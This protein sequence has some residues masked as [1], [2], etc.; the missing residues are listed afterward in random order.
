MIT[1]A[2]PRMGIQ[3]VVIWPLF[4]VAASLFV[5]M[6]FSP[7]KG[8]ATFSY[9]CLLVG[10]LHR[11]NRNV[12]AGLMSTGMSLDLLL[13]LVLEFQRSAIAT[14]ASG[15]LS[16]FQI[17][18]V[19]FSTLAVVFYFPTA[20]LGYKRFKGTLEKMKH[21]RHLQFGVVAFTLRTIGYFLMF[22]MSN[23]IG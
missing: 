1:K 10:I 17:A 11:K 22:S 16:V 20:V 18:H 8:I 4:A 6:V 13:V 19:V 23:S 9:L 2:I 12:H 14:S 15:S 5:G 7:Y 3:L 21:K